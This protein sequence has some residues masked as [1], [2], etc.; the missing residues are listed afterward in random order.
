MTVDRV[1]AVASCSPLPAFRPLR[2]ALVRLIESL[3]DAAEAG[4]AEHKTA[5]TF[6]R[7]AGSAIVGRGSWGSGEGEDETLKDFGGG[8]G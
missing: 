2:P 4:P 3:A 5:V 7:P 1:S 8:K 6:G